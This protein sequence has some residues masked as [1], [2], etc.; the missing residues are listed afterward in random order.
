LNKGGKDLCAEIRPVLNKFPFNPK[1]QVDASLSDFNSIF[2]PKDGA[3]WKFYE[4]SLKK[5]VTRQGVP[6]A[7][8]PVQLTP[9]F[10]EYLAKMAAFTDTAYPNGSADPHIR[11]NVKAIIGADTEKV[12]VT[13]DGQAVEF[14]P[15]AP[16]KDFVWPGQGLQGMTVRAKGGTEQAFA[17]YPGIWGIFRFINEADRHNGSLVEMTAKVGNQLRQVLIPGTNL[18]YVVRLDIT[19]NPPIFQKGY[20]SGI[21]CVA[22]VARQ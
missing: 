9:A 5:H 12:K 19:S 13:I 21:G 11:Y 2:S 14:T 3:I 6:V 15:S 10:R 4:A 7:G 18:P 22:E 8:S 17:D 1:S 16:A 20:F